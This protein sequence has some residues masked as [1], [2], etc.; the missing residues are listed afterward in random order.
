MLMSK[1]IDVSTEYL[2]GESAD[3][4]LPSATRIDAE[5]FHRSLERASIGMNRKSFMG[6]SLFFYAEDPEWRRACTHVHEIFDHYIDRAIAQR[7]EIAANQSTASQHIEPFSMLS[8]LVKETSDREFLRDQLLN[9]FIGAKDT[10]TI[11]ISDV[12]FNLARNP[13]VRKKLREEVLQVNQ[14]LSF[15]PFK[16]MRY[17]QC[18]LHESRY[19]YA[20]LF[21]K[22]LI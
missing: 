7:D 1:Y 5:S 18:V 15:E 8:E 9:V 16:S 4:L 17:L 10:A 20:K 6:R 22:Y 3:S 11:G 2:F 13:R 19:S 21:S 12:L 14:P